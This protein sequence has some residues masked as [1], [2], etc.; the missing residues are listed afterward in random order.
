MTTLRRAATAIR[1]PLTPGWGIRL[2]VATAVISGVAV[3]LNAFAVKQVPDPAV[4]TTLKNL[5][6]ALILI[7]GASLMGGAAEARTLSRRQWS[8]LL[9]VGL[10]GGSIPFLLFFT[11]LA[12]ASAPGAAFIHK[13]LFIWVALLAVP[14]LGERLG[15]LQ[16]GALGVLVLGQFLLVPPRLDGAGWGAGET[17]IAAATLLWAVEVVIVKQLLRGVSPAVVGAGRLGI[18]VVFLV[19]YLALT[20]GLAGI[21]TLSAEGW[22][23]VLVTGVVLAAYVGTWF[24]ALR[25]AP[26]SAVAAVLVVGAV[27]TAGLQALSNGA[28]PAPV[29]MMGMVVLLV[30]AGFVGWGALHAPRSDRAVGV[31]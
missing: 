14:F 25:R 8:T 20:G 3:W 10:I 19:G 1:L 24:A 5:V 15:R 13:T 12:Q 2:A 26:A 30:A 22:L 11:G 27:I 16:I 21:A 29:S 9:V 23:W 4:Y 6:A 7:G 17:M 31:A 18:G 28:A